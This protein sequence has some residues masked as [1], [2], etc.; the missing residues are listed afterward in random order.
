M[1]A[2]FL[3]EQRR[4][5][6][7]KPIEG[8]EEDMVEKLR[9]ARKDRDFFKNQ[10][11]ELQIINK[12]LNS[13]IDK[14]KTLLLENERRNADLNLNLADLDYQNNQL[15]KEKNE[16]NKNIGNMEMKIEDLENKVRRLKYKQ[17]ESKK[18][19]EEKKKQILLNE[20]EKA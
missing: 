8:F 6:E 14:L 13:E 4:L 11:Y 18:T 7:P 9:D 10:A 16:L 3:E 12:E 5:N 15:H 17:E 19:E 20:D 2:D 1:D